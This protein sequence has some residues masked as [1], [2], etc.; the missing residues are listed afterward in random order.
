MKRTEM[1]KILLV[2]LSATSLTAFAA[3]DS[4]SV[5]GKKAWYVPDGI[6]MEYAGGFGLASAGILY[7]GTG[8]SEVGFT[9]GYVPSKYGN[10]W[11]TNFLYSYNILP[12][13]LND[14]CE[15]HLFKTG[16]FVN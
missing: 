13:R 5:S 15:L 8:K 11:T 2:L 9:V 6:S 10:I 4:L 1:L 14:F 7:N 3:T 12:V 16:L